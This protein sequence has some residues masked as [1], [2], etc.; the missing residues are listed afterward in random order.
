MSSLG[1]AGSLTEA[2]GKYPVHAGTTGHAAS[3]RRASELRRCLYREQVA[4]FGV[5]RL[6]VGR[7]RSLT[8]IVDSMPLKST[9]SATSRA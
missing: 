2:G 6:A 3:A 4:E 5:C 8:E 9:M 1:P 7:Y